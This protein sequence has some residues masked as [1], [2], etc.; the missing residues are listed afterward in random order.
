[1]DPNAN[2]TKPG[3]GRQS[4]RLGPRFDR[5]RAVSA[6][7]P[8]QAALTLRSDPDGIAPE[9]A[10][11]FELA[12]SLSDFYSQ[13]GRIKGLEFLLEDDAEFEPD[14][15]FYVLQTK[16]GEQV[17]SE[18]PVGGRLYLAMPD[19]LA[20]REI[21]RLWNLYSRGQAMP[22]GFTS[23][24][25]LFD[26]LHDL[27]PWGPQDR[28]L[29]E[30]LE[31][32]RA[33]IAER[34]AD[35]VRFEVEMWFHEGLDRRVRAVN[36]VEA[37]VRELGGEIVTSAVIAAI[38]YHGLLVDL[39]P[40][41]VRELIDNT[42]VS[43]ARVDE[44][45]FLRPQSLASFRE[46][47]EGG[48]PGVIEPSPLPTGAPIVALLDGVPVANHHRLTG[49]IVLDDP[50]DFSARTPAARRAH[51]TSMAS[52]IV[53]GDLQGEGLPLGRPLYVRPVMVYSAADDAETTPPDRLPLDLVYLAVRRL[54][55]GEDGAPASAPQTLVINLSLGD[56]NRPFAG[57]ISPWARLIDWLSFRYSVL[58]LI[59]AGN[60][61]AWLPI[62]EFT[63]KA[64]F[65]AATPEQRESAIIAAL[66]AEK[67][68][69]SL[70]SPAES[71]NAIAVGAW[72][73]DEF[74]APPEAFHLLD[75]FPSGGLPNVSS[76]VGLGYR[77]TVK[78][79][80][81]F[82]G[83]RELVRVSEDEGHVWLAADGGGNYAG[84]MSAA[85]DAAATGR[86]DLQRRS[87]GTSN[88]TALLTRA[89][90]RIY[91]SLLE[92]GYDI[93]QSHAAVLL[94]ALLVHGA[95][96]GDAGAKLE[97]V[98]GPGGRQWQQHRDNLS[99]FLGYG[100]PEV[101]RVLD[102]AAERATLFGFGDIRRDEQREFDIP[103]PPSIEGSTELRRLTTTLAWLAPVNPRHQQYRAATLELMPNG[104]SAFSLAV[105][106]MT[107]QPTQHAM[108]RG[109]VTHCTFE[110]EDAVA[111][112]DAGLLK[113]RV[114]CRAQAGA[115]DDR[116]P[117]AVAISIETGV[118]SG[119]AI[120]D[121]VRAAIQPAVR[122]TANAS[123]S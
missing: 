81:L 65:S 8:A 64:E 35:P 94:K 96:W 109:T 36:A 108:G 95:K 116:V 73:A 12:G 86:L 18:K 84:Q 51:G 52:L 111:F 31:F 27:R 75:P 103:L 102:C 87:V 7:P 63:T 78:P 68:T 71:L 69:R 62:P 24:G 33:R 42:D 17:R 20:L 6:Q 54:M 98:F 118:G 45:M 44:I 29:P 46:P 105:E 80:V 77:R 110:G 19:M 88:A 93:P 117:F 23:W 37:Q 115:L 28:V 113:L 85:P 106:R 39:P 10:L 79:D 11:V 67:A 43:L 99:R 91:E 119:I 16:K 58:F 121:E 40:D 100:R 114:S 61:R 2:I 26:L 92:A 15:D 9:R 13:V 90:V 25:T 5:L 48:E 38:R 120:Y 70:L 50:D 49:R 30:V 53:H 56:L 101:D 34:P 1:V 112:L 55:E 97:E 4:Q 123:E 104:D 89:A 72:H 41:R 59:S 21:L 60:V 76:A 22:R 83:G 66:N 107:A 32:W 122:A 82:D 74:A 14:D 47:D 3:Y 57:R